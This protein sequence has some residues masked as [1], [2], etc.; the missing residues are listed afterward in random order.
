MQHSTQPPRPDPA[1]RFFVALRAPRQYQPHPLISFFDE[2]LMPPKKKTPPLA[3]KAKTGD[4]AGNAIILPLK[5]VRIPPSDP[6]TMIYTIPWPKLAHYG[7]THAEARLVYKK[8]PR[9]S[10]SPFTCSRSRFERIFAYEQAPSNGICYLL[11]LPL[12]ILDYIINFLAWCPLSS[13]YFVQGIKCGVDM[14]CENEKALLSA[15]ALLNDT[16]NHSV[17]DQSSARS[18]VLPCLCCPESRLR[19]S[20]RPSCA[21][22][23]MFAISSFFAACILNRELHG[24]IMGENGPWVLAAMFYLTPLYVCDTTLSTT[25]SVTNRT[26]G[27]STE[28]R[29]NGADLSD[30]LQR[31]VAQVDAT[32]I[33]KENVSCIDPQKHAFAHR[34]LLWDMPF[35]FK[36]RCGDLV[37]Q[38]FKT[39]MHC[40]NGC[41]TEEHSHDYYC[42]K[43]IPVSRARR[44][45]LSEHTIPKQ[46]GYPLPYCYNC[47]KLHGG[48]DAGFLDIYSH[49]LHF[50]L[51]MVERFFYF[52]PMYTAQSAELTSPAIHNWK[53]NFN[54]MQDVI[55]DLY[56]IYG[57]KIFVAPDDLA[58]EECCCAVFRVCACTKGRGA[59][60]FQLCDSADSGLKNPPLH[61][62]QYP[63]LW[64]PTPGRRSYPIYQTFLRTLQRYSIK[65]VDEDDKPG[66]PKKDSLATLNSFA[67]INAIKKVYPIWTH[68]Q[69]YS[70]C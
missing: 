13:S 4:S 45:P 16:H 23:T 47:F 14:Y 2:F 67:S 8:R 59:H 17:M 3:K 62:I 53:W 44:L 64:V 42:P 30:E 63:A 15:V 60:E 46:W 48:H 31:I 55:A 69:I 39:N 10:K 27:L 35:N 61:T 65:V 41:R 70:Y 36:Q 51:S 25:S 1:N 33:S 49:S 26:F 7:Q 28:Q 37:L 6:P 68:Y 66:V 12:E 24:L 19:H 57:T 20:F 52:L 11:S 32:Y 9:Q 58:H 54:Q 43:L 5:K 29:K 34:S 38:C 56:N 50:D 22:T 21:F 40:I 18:M